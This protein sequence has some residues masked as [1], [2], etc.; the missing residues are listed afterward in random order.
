MKF[1]VTLELIVDAPDL[2]AAMDIGIGAAKHL[3]ETYN[4]DCSINPAVGVQAH[5]LLGH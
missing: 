4:D 1:Q 5:M 2:D 3:A